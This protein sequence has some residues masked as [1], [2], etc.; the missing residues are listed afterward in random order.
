MI[1]VF[2]VR[3]NFEHFDVLSGDLSELFET[4]IRFHKVKEK[5]MDL[6]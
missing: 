5:E 3:Y 2:V 6:K 4:N 1:F